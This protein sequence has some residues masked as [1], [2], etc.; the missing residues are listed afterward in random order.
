[1]T[2]AQWDQLHDFELDQVSSHP[3]LTL[4]DSRYPLSELLFELQY[5]L[6]VS[7]TS[8]KTYFCLSCKFIFKVL[9]VFL[10]SLG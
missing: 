6:K 2:R 4:Q 10:A 8:L 7:S 5:P 9:A 1:M 3:I